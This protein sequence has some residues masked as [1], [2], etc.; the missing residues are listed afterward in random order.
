[1][2]KLSACSLILQ[3]FPILSDRS[4]QSRKILSI[5]INILLIKKDGQYLVR[6]SRYCGGRRSSGS[7]KA[8]DMESA[9][10]RESNKTLMTISRKSNMIAALP[11][12]PIWHENENFKNI[13]LSRV[14]TNSVIVS[15]VVSSS[16]F[17]ISRFYRR[18]LD[19]EKPTMQ[20]KKKSY[21][22]YLFNYF[23]SIK[24]H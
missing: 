12:F 3:N 9:R 10:K 20:E 6:S 17:A 24:S 22:T 2:A 16:T 8:R 21:K 4:R 5:H 13:L 19:Y 11:L 18:L 15:G 23:P 14:G 1:M 7:I